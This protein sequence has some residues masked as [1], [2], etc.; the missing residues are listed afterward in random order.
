VGGGVE[1]D[2][3]EGFA[4]VDLVGGDEGEGLRER[5]AD[6][7]D[8]LVF[9]R[10]GGALFDI[11]GQIDLHRF[12]EEAG[13]GEV[14]GKRCPAFGAEAGLFDHLAL[15]GGEWSFIGL[16]A[17]GRKFEE[18]LAGG[19]AVL[20]NEDEIGIFGIDGLV[21][22]KDDDGAVVADD[23]AGVRGGGTGFDDL[24][25]VDGEDGAFVRE[26]GGDEGGFGGGGPFFG[27]SFWLVCGGFGRCGGGS[28]CRGG[29][30]ATL[31]SCIAGWASGIQPLHEDSKVDSGR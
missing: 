6:D 27:G 20:A 25:G 8:V 23:V 4:V 22:R 7:L 28:F 9:L 21:Y 3:D 14:F 31:S 30:K 18:E 26:F 11:S 12:A 24:V 10:V 16:N 29:H 5:S 15:R 19:V 17:P 2:A 1:G 13:A